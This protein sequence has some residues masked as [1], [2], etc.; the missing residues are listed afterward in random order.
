MKPDW[1]KLMEEWKDS[2]TALVADVDCTAGGKA[3]CEKV[4]VRGYPTIKYGD[5]DD[6]QSYEGGRT[7][8]ALKK[9]ATDNLKPICGPKNLD[10]CDDEKKKKIEELMAMKEADLEAKVKEGEKKIEDVETAFK[11]NVEKL[12]KEYKGLMEKKD[13]DIKAVKE[14]GLGLMKS[15][16]SAAKKKDGKGAEL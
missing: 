11:E 14:S 8:D 1:D 12:Q 15:V 10:L 13:E 5:P 16:L 7:L 4:G 3:L 9:F 2:K 6:L